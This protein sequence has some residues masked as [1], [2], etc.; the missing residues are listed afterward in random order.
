MVSPPQPPWLTGNAPT[1]ASRH[2]QER[3]ASHAVGE[4]KHHIGHSG[5]PP[6]SPMRNWQ[7]SSSLHCC[8]LDSGGMTPPHGKR[9][10]DGRRSMPP[11]VLAAGWLVVSGNMNVRE[12]SGIS[13]ESPLPVG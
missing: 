4:R 11:T 12:T 5:G 1:V 13:K 7:Y 3:C 6:A 2:A 10:G 8:G 9:L